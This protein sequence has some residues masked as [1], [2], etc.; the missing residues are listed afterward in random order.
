MKM[1]AIIRGWVA[2]AGALLLACAPG[3]PGDQATPV[4]RAPAIFPDCHATTI[5]PGIAPL[6]FSIREPGE[7]FFVAITGSGN[8]CIEIASTSP[9]IIIPFGKWKR[10]LAQS[11]G[12]SVDLDIF[13]CENK[14]WQRFATLRDTVADEPMDRYITYRKIDNCLHW[15][16]MGIYQR[17]VRNFD[18]R[19]VL[20][21]RLSSAC[22]NCHQFRDN[23]ADAMVLQVRSAVHGTPMLV[24]QTD[25]GTRGLSAVSTRTAFSN[26]KAG[27][28]S[29]HPR[30]DIIAFSLNNYRMLMHTSAMETRDVFDSASDVAVYDA[31]RQEV[32]SAADLS[33]PDRI[34]TTPEW[35][36]DGR[37]LYFCSA[38]QL[39]AER[40]R[41]I[42]CDLMR[43]AFDPAT[44]AWGK[45]DTVLT[46]AQAGGS[47]VQPRFSPDGRYCLVSVTDYGDFPI[48]ITGSDL[49]IIDV[50]TGGF[51]KLAINSPQA[52]GW[53]C[54]SSNGRWISFSAKAGNGKFSR[55]AFCY[56][57][58]SGVAHKPFLLPQKDPRFDES[59]GLLF[60]KP[61]FTTTAIPFTQR[62]FQ[63]TLDA[64]AKGLKIDAATAA[65]P[66]TANRD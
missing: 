4:A 3:R 62:K 53:H 30:Q 2:A 24:G 1:P 32:F 38:P 14:R 42:R 12:G 56:F 47:I 10:L 61:E 57:D 48:D 21:N 63:A 18:E 66:Q 65:T 25:R 51:R 55:I 41:D 15:N 27:F 6:N 46:A 20:H 50:R 58:S 49:G 13:C 34:E 43:I 22:F 40:Y 9:R 59:C 37:F 36:R 26:G 8:R 28:T 16:W 19:T 54:W 23:T 31:K 17:D 5:P 52:E 45:L 33:R 60:N 39:A 44:R 35:S 64:C 7:R 11:R 29:W